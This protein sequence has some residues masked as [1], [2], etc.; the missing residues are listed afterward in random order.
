[1]VSLKAN[2]LSPMYWSHS[3]IGQ[4][5]WTTK[6]PLMSVTM[7]CCTNSKNLDFINVFSWIKEFLSETTYQK[8]ISTSNSDVFRLHSGIPQGGVLSP[9]FF[10]I[11]S[12]DL[13]YIGYNDEVTAKQYADDLKS[14]K[15]I[16]SP[17][18]SVSLQNSI[19]SLVQWSEDWQIPLSSTKTFHTRIG[20]SSAISSS[21][22][23]NGQEICKVEKVIYI[24]TNLI[25]VITTRKFPKKAFCRT[26]QSVKALTT[27]DS[28]D[29]IRVCKTYVRPLVENGTVVFCPHKKKD[30]A[31]IEKVQ[32]NSPERYFCGVV[33]FVC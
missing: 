16:N 28:K 33:A 19:N 26:Y 32:N 31:L 11:Y 24:T 27:N 29:L 15:V 14:Y 20:A 21:Y 18:D 12:A 6:S 7:S 3:M 22:F 13:A 1:M 25:S 4:A 30:M 5:H 17:Q 23:I 10:D 8:R 2:L 9:I